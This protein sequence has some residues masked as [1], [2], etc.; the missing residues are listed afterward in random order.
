VKVKADKE[1][2]LASLME[3]SDKAKN[4]ESRRQALRQYYDLLAKRMKKL[5]PSLSDWIDT[6]H[7]AYLRRLEQVRIEPTV[8]V[9][10]PPT[11]DASPSP[12]PT[13]K[14]K[15]KVSSPD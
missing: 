1:E 2:S 7:A 5:D 6:M 11:A 8:P 15:K 3:R 9:N 13:A 14:K 10:P 12:S 4:D